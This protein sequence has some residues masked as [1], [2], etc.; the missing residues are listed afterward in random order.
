MSIKRSKPIDRLYEE[1]AEYDLVIVP[2]APLAS[3]LNRRLEHPHF[4][5]FAI[6]PRRLAARRRETAEDRLAFLEVI[7][8]TDFSWK[9]AS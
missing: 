6:T 5:P 4:G 2:D 7:S 8:Q 3:A 1:V 9:Q